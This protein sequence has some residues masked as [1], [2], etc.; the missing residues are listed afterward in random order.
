ML[1]RYSVRFRYR[2]FDQKG[3]TDQ[4]RMG[5]P[6]YPGNSP[7]RPGGI[8]T[9]AHREIRGEVHLGDPWYIPRGKRA[10]RPGSAAHIPV[11][12]P[13]VA[14]RWFSSEMPFPD[15]QPNLLAM[16][17]KGDAV[18]LTRSDF[19]SRQVFAKPG[20]FSPSDALRL[21]GDHQDGIYTPPWRSPARAHPPHL[22]VLRTS[23]RN[24]LSL[25]FRRANVRCSRARRNL[26]QRGI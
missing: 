26:Q 21:S 1:S 20:S 9:G 15:Y 6:I 13:G 19:D 16:E 25:Y 14:P 8:S 2:Y 22:S 11:N 17:G 12:S 4:N 18:G 7:C 3:L 5:P 10:G 23:V 24:R